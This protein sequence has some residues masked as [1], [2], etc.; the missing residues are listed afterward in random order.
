MTTPALCIKTR[1]ATLSPILKE[2][3]VQTQ[4]GLDILASTSPEHQ[5]QNRLTMNHLTARLAGQAERSDEDA[6][7]LAEII[8][9]ALDALTQLDREWNIEEDRIKL[10]NDGL[11]LVFDKKAMIEFTVDAITARSRL[12]AIT[13]TIAQDPSGLVAKSMINLL[14]KGVVTQASKY[15]ELLISKL[16]DLPF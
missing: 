4:T 6:Y 7:K 14:L 3:V 5:E 9:D 15:C 2:A 13:L 8:N 11:F 1:L 12:F 10:V 16:E